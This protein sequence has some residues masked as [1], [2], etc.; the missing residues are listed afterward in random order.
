[1]ADKLSAQERASRLQAEWENFTANKRDATA[2]FEDEW[3]NK[4]ARIKEA[5]YE[6]IRDMFREGKGVP[7]VSRITGNTNY[8]ILYKLRADVSAGVP[9]QINKED[10]K[11]AAPTAAA[12]ELEAI[13]WE[14]HDHIGAHG[15]LLST[16]RK[17]VKFYGAKG[18]PFYG[19]WVVAT[20]DQALVEG[21]E[22]L[23]F[24]IPTGSFKKKVELVKSLI[25]GTYTK[26]I[27][28]A[29]NP[30]KS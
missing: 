27:R 6:A 23:L 1:M 8:T 29:D 24:S 22:A 14:Y 30:F 25:E 7:E 16:D 17:Y 15:W 26:A 11:L 10:V 28:L 19:E 2:K 3:R 4:K 13:E 20:V 21:N 5:L 9:R 18:T 12:P